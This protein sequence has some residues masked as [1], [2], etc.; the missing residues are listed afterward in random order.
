MRSKQFGKTHGGIYS[1]LNMF[2][3]I[4][5]KSNG[6]LK[7]RVNRIFSIR[8]NKVYVF[9]AT[10]YRMNHVCTGFFGGHSR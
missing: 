8:F 9:V 5:R 10:G 3:N 6:K 4:A 2:E 7:R 1:C